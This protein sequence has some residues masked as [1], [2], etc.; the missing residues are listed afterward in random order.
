MIDLKRLRELA[1]M[2]EGDAPPRAEVVDRR[3]LGGGHD[4]QTL[5]SEGRASLP[6]RS[7]PCEKCPWRKDRV[8]GFPHDSFRASADT[9]YPG[10]TRVFACH[11]AGSEKPQICA[12]S[13]L[14]TGARC[15][16]ALRIAAERGEY[17]P[18]AVTTGV[19][20]FESYR[21]MS[22][23][24]GLDPDDAALEPCQ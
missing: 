19:P 20:L 13:A 8:G 11:M 7:Q 24:N 18:A 6:V 23:A 12:G 4:V 1:T 22:I 16:D 5:R 17:D 14:S 21:A 15:N 9:A 10:S 2:G 3:D